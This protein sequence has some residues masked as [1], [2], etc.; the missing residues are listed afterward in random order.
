MLLVPLCT[1]PPHDL[2]TIALSRSA[3]R[4]SAGFPASRTRKIYSRTSRLRTFAMRRE[5]RSHRRRDV[6]RGHRGTEGLMNSDGSL[7]NCCTQTGVASV[8]GRRFLRAPTCPFSGWCAPSDPGALPYALRQTC[9]RCGVGRPT[10]TEFHRRTTIQAPGAR[11]G[12]ACQLHAGAAG[13]WQ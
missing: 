10:A 7:L 4:R 5:K 11:T 6:R 9:V 8:C 13:L 3:R 12:S 1:A 2:L